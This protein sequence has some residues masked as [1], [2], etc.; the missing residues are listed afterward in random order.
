MEWQV[1]VSS[2]GDQRTIYVFYTLSTA[3]KN[4]MYH[5]KS[6]TEDGAC[7]ASCDR[8]SEESGKAEM[9]RSPETV[10]R[11]QQHFPKGYTLV[12]RPGPVDIDAWLSPS[13]KTPE[14][15]SAEPIQQQLDRQFRQALAA[16]NKSCP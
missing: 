15:R 13:E 6:L 7:L 3:E 11:Y 1:Y 14:P 9:I 12:W 10:E 5:F 2:Y 16:W 8:D 4:P